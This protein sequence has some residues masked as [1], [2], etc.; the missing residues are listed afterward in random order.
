MALEPAELERLLTAAGALERGH[1]LLSSGRHSAGYVQ[2]AR[3]LELPGRARLVGEA[4]AERLAPAR[5]ESVLS[6]ALGGLLIGHEVAAALDLPFRFV[7]RAGAEMALRRGFALRAGERVAIVEDVVTTGRSTGEAIAVAERHGALPVAVG[8]IIDRSRG[9]GGF[10]APF[11]ALLV[12][13]LEDYDAADCPL[14]RAGTEP[15]KPG[16]RP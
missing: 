5:P 8:A 12:L 1:F 2:C 11:S 13:D 15:V 6:P 16:S 9:K 4:L 3:L 10:A 14:C 7:E